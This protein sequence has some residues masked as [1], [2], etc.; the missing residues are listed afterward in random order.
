MWSNPQ[1]TAHLMFCSF[2]IHLISLYPRKKSFNSPRFFI[3]S[4]FLLNLS[5]SFPFSPLSIM[6]CT[7]MFD[8]SSHMHLHAYVPPVPS[9]TLSGVEYFMSIVLL[10]L[11]F[12]P[13]TAIL[14]YFVCKGRRCSSLV[15]EAVM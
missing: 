13:L 3:N 1:V 4:S 11:E 10:V 5:P 12:E 2:H 6:H 8:T 9:Y 15:C 7:I 14:R